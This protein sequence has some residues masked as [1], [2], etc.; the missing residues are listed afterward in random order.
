MCEDWARNKRLD[1]GAQGNAAM[2]I[3]EVDGVSEKAWANNNIWEVE[4]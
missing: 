4:G 1:A 3:G 2:E